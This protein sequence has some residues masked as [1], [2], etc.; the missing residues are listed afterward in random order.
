MTPTVNIKR[1]ELK[2]PVHDNRTLSPFSL[3][4]GTSQSEE[5]KSLSKRTV[6]KVTKSGGSMPVLSEVTEP[7]TNSNQLHQ[8]REPFGDLMEVNR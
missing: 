8:D 3:R 4:Q 6:D 7:K 5:L 2:S 1:D